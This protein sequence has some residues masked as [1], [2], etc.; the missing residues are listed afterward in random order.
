MRR[1][2]RELPVAVRDLLD[3]PPLS[4]RFRLTMEALLD[5]LGEQG[6]GTSRHP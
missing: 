5:M 1:E 4:V 3:G 2:L 6:L